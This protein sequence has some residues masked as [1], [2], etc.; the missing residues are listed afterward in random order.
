MSDEEKQYNQTALDKPILESR[1]ASVEVIIKE[2][3]AATVVQDPEGGLQAWL[4]VLGGW[5]GSMFPHKRLPL[6]LVQIYGTILY[7]RRRSSFRCV[8]GL[9]HG[10]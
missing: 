8:S 9:L 4:T 2:S 5:G 3:P 10:V 6:I 1:D 7:F